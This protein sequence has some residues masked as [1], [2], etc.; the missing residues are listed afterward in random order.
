MENGKHIGAP[1]ANAAGRGKEAPPAARGADEDKEKAARRDGLGRLKRG[2]AGSCGQARESGPIP[3][4]V[5]SSAVSE[6]RSMAGCV[7]SCVTLGWGG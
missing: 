7:P 4:G 3:D 5:R 6:G 2:G 1:A